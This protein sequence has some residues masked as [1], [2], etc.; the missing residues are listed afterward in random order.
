MGII[1]L[2]YD[3]LLWHYSEAIKSFFQIWHNFLWFFFN[4]FSVNL[5]LRT[6]FSP[7]KR[8]QDKKKPGFDLGELVSRL[9]MNTMMRF[10]GFL[11]R[12]LFIIIGIISDIIVL[13]TGVISFLV[14]IFMPLII[15]ILLIMGIIFVIK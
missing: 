12:L 7:W 13:V 9:I 14:W 8:I 5:L 2:M 11:L 4:F 10:V 1:S 15:L 3:Y 6:L